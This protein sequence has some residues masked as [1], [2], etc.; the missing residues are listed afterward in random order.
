[1]YGWLGYWT[2][3]GSTVPTFFDDR[4]G[5]QLESARTATAERSE[6][7]IPAS[8]DDAEPGA[9]GGDVVV[10]TRMVVVA[11][12]M[13]VDVEGAEVD[14]GVGWLSAA[15]DDDRAAP[16][17]GPPAAVTITRARTTTTA[18]PVALRPNAHQ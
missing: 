8:A 12:G 7:S 6:A 4:T 16:R 3:L 17:V 13:V 11:A 10:D 14:P 15:A 2:S 1:M 18:K 5:T 9:A